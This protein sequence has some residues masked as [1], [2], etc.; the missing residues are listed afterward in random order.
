MGARNAMALCGEQD[1]K[2]MR[3][4][5]ISVQDINGGLGLSGWGWMVKGKDDRK[6][7]VR[8]NLTQL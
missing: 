5:Q 8:S 2:S 3:L 1:F 4:F 7:G 6:W